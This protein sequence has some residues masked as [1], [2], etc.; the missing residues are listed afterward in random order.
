[1]QKIWADTI[2][3]ESNLAQYLH[4]LRKTLG[5]TSDG[6]PYIETLKRRGYRF[7]GVVRVLKDGNGLSPPIEE[8]GHLGAEVLNLQPKVSSSPSRRVERH[9]NVLAVADWVDIEEK[10]EIVDQIEP[11]RTAKRQDRSLVRAGGFGRGDLD[12]IPGVQPGQVT[13]GRRGS[14]SIG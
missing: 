8:A 12:R 5:A 14:A 9:G 2:V 1:M 4:V 11:D 7:N 10:P 3:E 6:K 13:G